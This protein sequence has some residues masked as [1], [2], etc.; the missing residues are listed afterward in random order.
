M[1]MYAHNANGVSYQCSVIQKKLYNRLP[2]LQIAMFRS[3]SQDL[4]AA[5][6]QQRPAKPPGALYNY[7]LAVNDHMLH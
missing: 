7:Y 6:G 4:V 5:S 3:S 2:F 1:K